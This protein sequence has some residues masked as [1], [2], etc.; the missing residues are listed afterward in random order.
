M[1]ILATFNAIRLGQQ[2]PI[3]IG[4]VVDFAFV[5]FVLGMLVYFSVVDKAKKTEQPK[6]EDDQ[7]SLLPPVVEPT[8]S[9]Q[10]AEPKT[11]L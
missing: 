11:G 7:R 1:D 4:N 6:V 8:G 2:W 9:I 3:Y 5:C 10:A